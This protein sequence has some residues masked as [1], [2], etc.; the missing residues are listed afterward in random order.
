M[1]L[2]HVLHEENGVFP[3]AEHRV[4]AMM[5]RAWKREGGVIGIIGERGAPEG[6]IFLIMDQPWYS[7]V[8]FLEEL[9][10]FVHPRF[11]KSNHA[12]SLVEF[13]K[14]CSQKLGIPLMIGIISNHRTKEKV[15]LYQR[16]LGAPVGAFFLYGARTGE[17]TPALAEAS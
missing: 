15:R 9:L 1:A 16:Q 17:V 3:M 7:D 14:T 4:R 8:V 13:A 5:A 11:R 2:C 6:C 12:K 10:N